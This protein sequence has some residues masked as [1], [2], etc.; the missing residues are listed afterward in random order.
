[1]ALQID[2]L[3]GRKRLFRRKNVKRQYSQHLDFL[4]HHDESTYPLHLDLK[5]IWPA[6]REKTQNIH[7]DLEGT[8]S[9]L[10]ASKK[11]KSEILPHELPH[12]K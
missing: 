6:P 3:G 1:M 8:A 11:S 7:T 5:N 2:V 4:R 12:K 9:L 10:K